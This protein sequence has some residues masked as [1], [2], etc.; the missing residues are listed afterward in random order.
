MQKHLFIINPVAGKKDRSG[1]IR[2]AVERL[3]LTD[4][5]EIVITSCVRDATEIV[6][7]HLASASKDCFLRIYS[8]GGDGTLCEIIDGVYRSE[9]KN[10]AV[11]VV[12]IGSGNDF[13]KYFS[14]IPAEKFRSLAD[15]VR[16]KTENCDILSVKDS[17][18]DN[19]RVSINIVSAGFDAAVAKGMGKYKRLP[20][21]NGSGAYSL[22]VIECFISKM[23][24]SFTL[25]AD[26]AEI[27]DDNNEYLFTIAANGSYYGGGFKA[28]PIS[29]IRDGML[30][31]IRIKPVSRLTFA[32]LIG[33]FK[34]GEHLSKMGKFVTHMRC[35]ELAILADEKIDVN[36]DGEIVP[37]TNPV[38]SVLP[39]EIKLILPE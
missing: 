22:S 27:K 21:I 34:R 12:P 24:H 1:I 10:C 7:N 6:K 2:K 28:S 14:D 8:C 16:G 23:K 39:E 31:F 25:I 29:D 15:M 3:L 9:N 36:I 4:P 19:N 11:G 37:M 26:G 13:V 18:S 33:A 17:A 38:I 30:D 35:R 20:F 32:T 5:Y